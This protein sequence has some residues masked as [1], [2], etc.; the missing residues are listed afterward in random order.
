MHP[1]QQKILNLA[2]RKNV[3]AMGPRE[4]ARE[5]GV[6]HPQIALHHL[7]QLQN[8]GLLKD[9]NRP[10]LNSL[11][12]VFQKSKDD[13]ANIPILGSANCGVA[14]LVAEES[15]E[16]Y[17]TISKKLL[18]SRNIDSLFVLKASGNS[19]NRARISGST[20][21]DGDYLI[22]DSSSK[23]SNDGDYVVSVI[24]GYANV[25]KFKMEPDRISLLSES[26][27]NIAPIYIHPDDSYLINGKVIQVV[28]GGG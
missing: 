1:N 2:S 15:F 23:R 14:T 19:L 16:G 26:S 22:I 27:E 5:I 10:L 9:R 4:L 17:L 6:N 7:R 18:H 12:E 25:K 8:K 3:L 11:R 24:D 28:K 20:V 21:D 13:I